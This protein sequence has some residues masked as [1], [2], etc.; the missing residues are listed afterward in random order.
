MEKIRELL[1][2]ICFLPTVSSRELDYKSELFALA[3][4][5]FDEMYEDSFGDL[6]LVVKSKKPSAPR[7]MIDAHFDVVG[8]M[9]SKVHEDGFL[10]ISPIGGVD[11]RVLG[12][13]GAMVYGKER[14]EGVFTSTPPHLL[15]NSKSLPGIEDIYIDCGENASLVE[16]GDIATYKPHFT[17]LLNNRVSATGLDDKACVCAMLDMAMHIDKERLNYDV[18][19]VISAQEETGKGG[20]RFIAYD[21]K[22]DIAIVT[23]A[24]FARGEDIENCDSIE[25]GEGAY[26]DASAVTDVFL[27]RGIIKALSAREI[28]LQV[29]CEPSRTHTN[30]EAISIAGAGVRTALLGVAVE[31]MHTPSEIVSLEDIKSLS[32]ALLEIAYG[33]WL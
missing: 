23:D 18:Y 32:G 20:A 16:V 30:N 6:V 17:E 28:K 7:L 8:F 29:A 31:G 21:I 5:C 33:E 4:D 26:I 19:I 10:S 22:P 11:T 15:K 25:M 1:K 14:V 27:T 13:S 3:G 2:K 9:V 24:F 12:A